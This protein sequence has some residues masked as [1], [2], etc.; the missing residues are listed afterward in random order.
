MQASESN[1][2]RQALC[3][4][5]PPVGSVSEALCEALPAVVSV[6]DAPPVSAP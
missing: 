1:L 3:E 5:L 6:S 2:L 4:S